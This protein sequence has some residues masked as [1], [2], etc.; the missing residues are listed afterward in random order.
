MKHIVHNL[1]KLNTLLL[2]LA[3]MG[4]SERG[5]GQ[6]TYVLCTSSSDLTA[7]SKYLIVS[8]QS[9]GTARVMG[10]Q[11][12][13]NRPQATNSVTISSGSITTVVATSIDDLT[14]GYELTLGGTSG[15]WTFQDPLYS[16]DYLKATSS[17]SNNLRTT[18]GIATW[19]VTFSSNA[20]VMTCITGSFSRNI[21]RYNS[22]S[23]LFSCYSSGQAS[24]YLFKKVE[25][26]NDQTS[27]VESPNEQIATGNIVSTATSSSSAVE[28]F[29]FK[30]S[31]LA[32]ADALPTKV[33]QVKITKT[34]TAILN[35]TVAGAQLFDG[36]TQITTGTPVITANDITF[37][38]TSGNL[39]IATNSSRE[40]TLK[41]WLS[42]TVTDNS[43]LTFSVPQSSHGFTADATGSGFATDFGAAV[44]GNAMTIRVAA[45]KLLFTTAPSTSACPN[46][47]LATPPVVKATD[48]NGNTDSDY[49]GAIDLT[50]SG[51]I[52]MTGYQVAE[53]SLGVASFPNL[54]FTAT[55]NVT[56]TANAMGLTSSSPTASIA[57]S[58]GNVASP[59]ASNGNTQS[60]LTWTNPASCSDEIMIIAKAGSAVTASPSG[61][62]TAYTANLAF[63]SGTPYDGGFV[64]YKGSTSSQ[65]VTGL[66]NGTIY[67]F[68]FFTRKGTFWS[69][70]TT[71]T[72]TPALSSSTTD[73]FRTR[74]TGNWNSTDTWQSSADGT[75]N[76]INAT[77][78]PTS[79]ANTITILN[80]HTVTV[81]ASVT[82]DQVTVNSGGQITVNSSQTLTIANGA[83]LIDLSVT[84]TIEN[85]GTLSLTGAA[86]FESGSI[87][88]WNQNGGSLNNSNIT[89]GKGSTVEITGAV[90]TSPTNLSQSFHNFTWDC[91]GQSSWLSLSLTSSFAVNG[92]LKILST[93]GGSVGVVFASSTNRT[94]NIGGDFIIDGGKVEL[95]N[96]TGIVTMNIAGN[97]E[98]TSNLLNL[99]DLGWSDGNPSG[100]YR[101]ILYLS[102]NLSIGNGSTLTCSDY[103]AHDDYGN[104]V[105]EKQG[106]QT[107]TNNGNLSW[108][109]FD[110]DQGS[111][112]LLNSN[113]DLGSGQTY[114]EYNHVNVMNG[115]TLNFNGFN[116]TDNSTGE[117]G[118]EV[119]NGGTLIITSADGI[120]TDG[121]NGNIQVGY[122]TYNTGANYVYSGTTPQTTGDGLPATVNNLTVSGTSDL[123][124]SNAGLLTVA[125]N[126]VIGSTA[127]LTIGTAQSV[128]VTGNLTNSRGDNGL[129]IK[130]G[131]SGTGSLI[132]NTAGVGATVERYISG[133]WSTTTS[134][135][136][137]ISSPVAAQALSAFETTGANNGYD[138]Y[139]WDEPNNIWKNYKDASFATWNG[140]DNFNV[141]QGYMIS[142]EANQT[143]TFTGALN[144]SNFTKTNLSASSGN[145][146][147][148]HLLGNPFASAIKWNDGNWALTNVAGTAKVWNELN[149]SYSDI[150]A[151][152]II[153]SAQGFMIQVANGTN[154]LTIPTASR[155]HSAAAWNKSADLD[156]IILK[157]YETASNSAQESKIFI[158]PMATANFDFDFDSRFLPGYAPQFYSEAGGEKLSTNS[159]P[160][161]STETVIPLGFVKNDANSFSLEFIQA[162]PGYTTYLTDKKMN[163]VINLDM[164]PVYSFTAAPGD[165]ASRFSLHFASVGLGETPTTQSVLAYYHDGALYVNNTEA[166]AEI[167]LFGISGQL[168]KQQTATAGL[169]TLQAG[170]L[171][172]GVYVVRVQSAA[173]TYS[174]K[175]IV[176]R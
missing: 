53:A 16:N 122:P 77:L 165:D 9:N 110:I 152:G 134:G 34:G 100:D 89:W 148:W 73:H 118:F 159:L 129:V 92:D 56:L 78:T 76:W 127:K 158:N 52:I 40:I 94:Y 71:T 96:G 147:F 69:S 23:S 4:V 143:K 150:V 119:F 125:G 7:G 90:S 112:L 55:G 49:T 62:G 121:S 161:I 31:D 97:L 3:L 151:N 51:S 128:S 91:S 74:A 19:T 11:S 32:T 29:K 86:N 162:I 63:G 35:T 28:T 68:T 27:K 130:S 43:T 108:I 115:G 10:Y 8:S 79:A 80:G 105:F 50:N 72:A 99:L 141:G 5:W 1:K 153:P 20:A 30:I 101:S 133:S 88:R 142:Y 109:D 57:I 64:V 117:G 14:R 120:A 13:N 81:T 84:G 103:E 145:N 87:F 24:V 67:H 48:V 174:S 41:V 136:H 156:H 137:Q 37:P 61:D 85:K 42:S 163:K 58:V 18:S 102:G 98:L 66:T 17:S 82:V 95:T 160:F 154:S 25:A 144:V 2:L 6:A 146:G 46:T 168:L 175:V 45:S 104:I 106:I 157:V 38:I 54:Q 114:Y 21:L 123:T 22:S 26:S 171:S 116:V 39:D 170:K 59:A 60:V 44:T 167:M 138:L 139:G 124:L 83:D 75:T 113:L 166:G 107:F 155:V 126:L 135:W 131:S 172:A 47:N 15:A 93:G 65:T 173:G 149:K 176:T 36:V 12:T 111:T 132:H 164:N 140:S 33:T 70:G 169:N